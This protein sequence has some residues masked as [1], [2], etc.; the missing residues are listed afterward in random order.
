MYAGVVLRDQIF[1]LTGRNGTLFGWRYK[2]RK[3]LVD[4]AVESVVSIAEDI[5]CNAFERGKIDLHS[6]MDSLPD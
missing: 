6:I 1:S 2:R 3:I 5:I 4:V